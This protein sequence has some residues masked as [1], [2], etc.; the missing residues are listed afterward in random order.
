M[1]FSIKWKPAQGDAGLSHVIG[2]SGTWSAQSKHEGRADAE[3]PGM[4]N[5]VTQLIWSLDPDTL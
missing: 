3:A 4:W 5:P 2:S 1:G